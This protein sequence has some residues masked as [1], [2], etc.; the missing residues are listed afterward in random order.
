MAYI[1]LKAIRAMQ[2]DEQ[3]KVESLNNGLGSFTLRLV[4]L[5]R[6]EIF[7]ATKSRLSLLTDSVKNELIDLS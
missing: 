2:Q 4:T 1:R 6:A 7:L 5:N 3:D